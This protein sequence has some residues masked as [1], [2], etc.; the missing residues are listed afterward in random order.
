MSV[1]M[2]VDDEPQQRSLLAEILEKSG[3][4]CISMKDGQ[5]AV[6]Y[7][8]WNKMP[9]PEVIVLDLFMPG[10]DG[11][12]VIRALRNTHANL[13]IIALSMHGTI[14]HSEQA[15]A[16]GAYD[17]INKPVSAERLKVAVANAL[18]TRR[19]GHELEQ[20][21]PAPHVYLGPDS[22]T[23]FSDDW[24]HILTRAAEE[25]KH[26]HT[27]L[28][29]GEEGVGKMTLA[30]AIHAQSTRQNSPFVAVDTA[31]DIA[32]LNAL[33]LSAKG[34]TLA[35][36]HSGRAPE[37][38]LRGLE[39][40][41]QN[42]AQEDIRLILC[43]RTSFEQREEA[44]VERFFHKER[45]NAIHIP[46]LRERKQDIL[47][48]AERF[49]EKASPLLGREKPL[50]SPETAQMLQKYPWPGNIRQFH[51]ELFTALLH[52]KTNVLEVPECCH[53]S[54]EGASSTHV[55]GKMPDAPPMIPL[56]DEGG[57][58]RSLEEIEGEVIQ[59][60]LNY[61]KTSRSDIARMLGI[62]RTT[63]YRKAHSLHG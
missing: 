2:I 9:A 41:Y 24:L 62:G 60:A 4:T 3:Y 59:F 7:L 57:N 31:Q 33:L 39:K 21:K 42:M 61:I 50:I 58:L 6:D 14:R 23:G 5:E 32:S 56:V 28:I 26:S 25:A 19:M 1:V 15:I 16:T 46:P 36:N 22:Y 51:A 38:F 63:L 44:L 20:L 12:T 45:S 54:P 53:R 30:R 27:L 10:T 49:L 34:G 55:N 13:P 11:L 52:S 35:V 37:A 48:M 18:R 40:L 17:Y 29:E 47:L 8:L 43:L